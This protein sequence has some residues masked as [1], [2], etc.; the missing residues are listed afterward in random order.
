MAHGTDPAT[1]APDPSSP[2]PLQPG[3]T[4]IAGTA[5]RLL[6][7]LSADDLVPGSRLPAERQLAVELQVGRAAVRE[8]LAALELL[9]VVESR[10]GSGTYLTDDPSMLLP[11][12]IE[13][14]LLLQRPQTMQLVEARRH[15]EVSLAGIA[16]TRRDPELLLVLHERALA[17]RTAGEAGD[18]DAFVEAD[19][20]FHLDVARLSGNAV[21]AGMLDSVSSLLRVWMARGV[22]AGGGQ[23]DATLSEHQAVLDAIVAGRSPA[24]ERAM[25]DHM[26]NAEARLLESLGRPPRG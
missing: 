19:A 16:A 12:A 17:M 5:R 9:G 26:R 25:R 22:R 21:L 1:T 10:H 15:L 3:D 7:Q 23:V 18:L 6:R 13:W 8:V 20:L 14:G 2:V 11:Q 24:A 4:T